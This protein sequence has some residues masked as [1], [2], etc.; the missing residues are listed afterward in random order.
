MQAAVEQNWFATL[1]LLAW[2]VVALWL[3]QTQP[4]NKATLWMI[5]GAYLLLPVGASIKLAEGI[6]QLDKVSIPALCALVGCFFFARRPLRLWN[7]FGLAEVLLLMMLAGPFMTSEL[8]HDWVVS[9]SV[10]LPGVGNYDAL[11]A[12]VAQL[13]FLLPF[14]L[15]RQLFRASGDTQQILRTLI[16]AG[17]LYSLPILFEIRMSPQLHYWLYGYYPHEFVQQVRDGGYRPMVFI[18]HGLRVAFFTMTVTVAAAAFWR[19]QTRVRRL[20]PAGVMAYLSAILVL[21]KA[22]AATTYAVALVPLIRWA[23][24]RLQVRIA[25]VLVAFALLYPLLRISDLAPIHSIIEAASLL[26]EERADSLKFRFDH[27]EQQLERASQRI[28]FGWG[29]Y[30]RSR[31]YDQW[32][33]DISVTDGRWVITLGTFGLFGLIAEFGLLAFC[34]F[35]AASVLSLAESER[36]KVFLAALALIVAI[37]MIDL[38]PNSSL[39]PLT[40][41]FAGALMGRADALRQTSRHLQRLAAV[42]RSTES[43]AFQETAFRS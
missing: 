13:L 32:G 21:C 16:A 24:P 2:P 41:L 4:L 34:V 43:A 27:E 7:G 12:V 42:S 17:L 3:Y 35:R 26:G 23:S 1:A 25:L 33:K 14:F 22:A 18:G 19:T 31:I 9:G 28:W 20:A 15:G 36:D 40:W 6:P 30:G 5:L 37:T 39:T 10:T 29:R 38:L 8:N 11:S